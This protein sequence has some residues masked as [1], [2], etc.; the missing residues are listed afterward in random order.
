VPK[1]IILGQEEIE[2]E[3]GANLLRVIQQHGYDRALPAT[4]DGRCTCSTCAVRVLKGGDEVKPCEKDLLKDKIEKNWRL[5]CQVLVEQD[6]EVEVP[7][8]EVAEALE[9]EPG[10]LA[11]ILDYCAEHLPL[12]HIRSGQRITLKRLR[13]LRRRVHALVEGGGDPPDFEILRDLL[14]YLLDRDLVKEIPSRH[15]FTERTVEM[16]VQVFEKRIPAPLEEREE[17]LTYPYYLYVVF[18]LFFFL[19][20]GLSIY[21]LFVDAPLEQAATPTFTPNPE[22]AP[23]YFLGIQE[24]LAISPNLGGFLNSIAL[25]G[26]ILPGLL[27]FFWMAI[28]YIEHRLEF[29]R[30]DRSQPPG[31]RLR[32][33]PVTVALFTL[34]VFLFV[35]LIIVGTYFRGPNWEFVLPWR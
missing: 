1:V 20:G 18:A 6:I 5:S 13:D 9:I 27:V 11:D 4:C 7:G 17:I 10:L 12:A 24:L 30:S 25:G 28:P 19:L 16:M 8:Y 23:W 22:K 29:W 33:R 21:A 14:V 3:A 34:T 31:R 26:V 32:E 15:P 2:V 35:A